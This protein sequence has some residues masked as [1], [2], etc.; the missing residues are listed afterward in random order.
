MEF[1]TLSTF[2]EEMEEELSLGNINKKEIGR[3][4]IDLSKDARAE[5]LTDMEKEEDLSLGS[6]G[7]SFGKHNGPSR[8]TNFSYSTGN[9][10]YCSMNCG[11][12][13]N[14]EGISSGGQETR[15]KS[16]GKRK[17]FVRT[18][19]SHGDDFGGK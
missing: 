11:E 19:T 1:V 3:N 4:G 15:G 5:L 14:I 7:K 10:T 6:K 13:R 16:K 9:S 12:E 18:P 8:V 17:I 2:A